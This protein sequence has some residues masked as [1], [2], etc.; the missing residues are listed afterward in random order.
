MRPKLSAARVN[1]DAVAANA[2]MA[3]GFKGSAK[4]RR[5]RESLESCAGMIGSG[6]AFAGQHSSI[7]SEGRPGEPPSSPSQHSHTAGGANDGR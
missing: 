5:S 2:M 1:E 6:A 3:I 7:I 4:A